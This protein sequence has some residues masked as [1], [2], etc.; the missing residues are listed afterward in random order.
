MF[1][2]S[3]FVVVAGVFS[4][5]PFLD[6]E[7][8]RLLLN[9][10]ISLGV[11]DWQRYLGMVQNLIYGT[12]VYREI[13]DFLRESKLDGQNANWMKWMGVSYSLYMLGF[14]VYHSLAL[15]A[16][17][18]AAGDLM[19]TAIMAI[20]IYSIGYLGY[21][22]PELIG[23]SSIKKYEKTSISEFDSSE[24][25]EQLIS[26]VNDERVYLNSNISLSELANQLG[27]SRHH[28][29]R[30]VNENLGVSFSDLINS[31]RID[32]AKELMNRSDYTGQKLIAI[33]FDSGFN[34]KTNFYLAFK[35][36]TGQ[37]PSEYKKTLGQY[38]Q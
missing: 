7:E 26:L 28:L 33:A 9:D 17:S 6:K 3:P 19:I 34:N 23:R 29:S 27:I 2:F 1:I 21:F 13:R 31:K 30:L 10:Y 20:S 11:N 36:H 32:R 12:L 18:T 38:P 8:G 5:F 25:I 24:K 14:F 16:E 4:V 15:V 37:S 22:R 35:K